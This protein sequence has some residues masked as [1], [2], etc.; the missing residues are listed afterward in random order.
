MNQL[1]LRIFSDGREIWQI[2]LC[3]MQTKLTT[4]LNKDRTATS[5]DLQPLSDQCAWDVQKFSSDFQMA[6]PELGFLVRPL[7]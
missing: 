4:E 2:N 5:A 3:H 7:I 6:N 1:L